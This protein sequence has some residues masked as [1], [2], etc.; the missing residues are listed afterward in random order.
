MRR[1]GV[2]IDNRYYWHQHFE[3]L[4]DLTRFFDGLAERK[5]KVKGS[6]KHVNFKGESSEDNSWSVTQARNIRTNN[7]PDTAAEAKK[8]EKF[9]VDCENVILKQFQDFDTQVEDQQ[10]YGSR[11]NIS[12]FIAGDDR[13]FER[14]VEPEEALQGVGRNVVVW[15]NSEMLQGMTNDNLFWLVAS[16]LALAKILR[17]YG[18]NVAFNCYTLGYYGKCDAMQTYEVTPFGEEFDYKKIVALAIRPRFL[19]SIWNG[20]IECPEWKSSGPGGGRSLRAG[21]EKLYGMEKDVVLMTESG[22]YFKMNQETAVK[23]IRKNLERYVQL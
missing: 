4:N 19:G 13:P 1:S 2:W 21:E 11:L 12:R 6:N 3:G 23:T 20:Y 8:L 10:L 9:T 22:A 5:D 14:I 16:G 7:F 17:R 18:Y 15:V